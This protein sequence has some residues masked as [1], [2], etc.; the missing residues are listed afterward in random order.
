MWEDHARRGLPAPDN[1]TVRGHCLGQGANAPDLSTTKDFIRFLA[2]TSVGKIA[3]LPTVDSVK[4][5]AEWFF[6]GFTRVTGTQTVL[7]D[8]TEVYKVSCSH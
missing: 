3:K 2:T 1:A 8:R 6:A 4:I 7:E 5:Y